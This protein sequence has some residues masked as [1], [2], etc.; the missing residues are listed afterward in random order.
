MTS[1]LQPGESLTIDADFPGGNIIVEEIA[2]DTVVLRQD[3]RDTPVWWFNWRFRVRGAAGRTLRF[4]FTDGDVFGARG[5]CVS[6]DGRK[7]R[8]LG[9]G[10]LADHGF[11]FAMPP[12]RDEVYFSFCLPYQE[13]HLRAYLAAHPRVRADMLSTTEAGRTLEHLALASARGRGK[14]L[15][16]ARHHACESMANYVIEGLFDAWQ[17]RSPEA[18]FLRNALDFHAIPFMDKDG[19]EAGDQG[20][21]RLPHDHNRDYSAS[22]RYAAVRALPAA[23]DSWRAPLLLH[24]DLHCPW[25]RGEWNEE[26]FAVGAD[27]TPADALAHFLTLL[28]TRSAGDPLPFTAA[29]YLPFGQEWNVESHTSTD[30]FSRHP[31]HPLAFN[32]EFPYAQAGGQ[33]VTSARARTFGRTLGKVVARYFA[34]VS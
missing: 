2:G 11:T 5:P 14:V 32:I 30:F 4:T 23:V 8:W 15:F 28:Q 34:P 19:V 29:H 12:N 26:I 25:I 3:P 31:Q 27:G 33:T 16:T 22:P 18:G 7:W 13:S 20:K 24:L 1:S 9:R 21:N 17:D 6:L 10:I